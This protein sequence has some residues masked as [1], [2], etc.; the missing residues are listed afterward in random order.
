MTPVS[1]AAVAVDKGT[2]NTTRV[3]TD[4]ESE[5]MVPMASGS[6]ETITDTS[7]P[8]NVDLY[9]HYKNVFGTTLWTSHVR[10]YFTWSFGLITCVS[11]YSWSSSVPW[12]W[13]YN[14]EI[15]SSASGGVGCTYYNAFEQGSYTFSIP[16][17]P[18]I[19]KLPYINLSDQIKVSGAYAAVYWNWGI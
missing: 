13:T 17:Y 10:D 19:N 1:A 18:T 7:S 15:S 5:Q 8:C 11:C 4:S 16:G 3:V 6:G 2:G 12:G 14:G 9:V